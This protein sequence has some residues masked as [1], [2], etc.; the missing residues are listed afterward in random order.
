MHILLVSDTDRS[1]GPVAAALLGRELT[2][3][4]VTDVTASS[5][6]VHARAGDGLS[7]TMSWAAAEHGLSLREHRARALDEDLIAGADVL[8]TMTRSQADHVGLTF[9][10]V[11]ERLFLVG[12]L[13]ELLRMDTDDVPA[14]TV[15]TQDATQLAAQLAP[16]GVTVAVTSTERLAQVLAVARTRRLVRGLRED[17]VVADEHPDAPRVVVTRLLSDLVTIAQQFSG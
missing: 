3:R 16:A 12:E 14:G 6:G 15:A 2:R 9:P 5:A 7:F 8:L 11:A 4:G 17:D 10:R 13:A 1:R